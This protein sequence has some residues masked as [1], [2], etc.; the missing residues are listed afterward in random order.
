MHDGSNPSRPS[1]RSAGSDETSRLHRDRRPC[2]GA[3]RRRERRHLLRLP[4]GPSPPAPVR[5]ARASGDVMGEEL[6]ARL[7]QSAG[8]PRQLPRL[9]R[10]VAE[11]R[12]NGRVQ[13][14][15]RRAGAEGGRRAVRRSREHGHRELLRGV[16]G[17]GH[18][19]RG[20][21]RD[22][23]LGRD[24]ARGRPLLRSLDAP[25]RTRPVDCGAPTYARRRF[26][27]GRRRHARELPLPL[28]RCRSLDF[29]VMETR[30]PLRGLLPA[31]ALDVWRRTP[32]KGSRNRRGRGGDRRDCCPPR[33]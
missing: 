11:L 27:P 5:G 24:R 32:P 22:P 4:C 16:R 3:R 14:L 1:H 17:S 10:A 13:R 6:R 18:R 23:H 19:G 31:S 9:E 2:D 7:V 30:V 28:P 26:L 8:G 12:G 29:H 20:F 25:V 21:R 33:D 15:A